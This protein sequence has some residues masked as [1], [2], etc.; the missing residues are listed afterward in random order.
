MPSEP[1]NGSSRLSFRTGSR[2]SFGR[3]TARVVRAGPSKSNK[4]PISENHGLGMADKTLEGAIRDATA[5]ERKPRRTTFPED[6]YPEMRRAALPLGRLSVP[7]G[8]ARREVRALSKPGAT[9]LDSKE[10][11][12]LLR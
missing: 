12:L 3:S 2:R 8:R 10:V 5:V 6:N 11:H 7:A 1:Q 4:I 9:A